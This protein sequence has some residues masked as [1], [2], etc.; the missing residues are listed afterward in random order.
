MA[1]NKRNGEMYDWVTH[2]WNPLA[3]ACSH[4]CVYCYVKSMLGKPVLKAKYSGPPR[5]RASELTTRL[6]EGNFIFICNMTDLFAHDVPDTCIRIILEYCARFPNRYLIQTKNPGR[7]IPFLTSFH[8]G[9]FEFVLATTIETDDYPVEGI[10]TAPPIYERL[11]A[12]LRYAGRKT[13]TIEPILKFNHEPLVNVLQHIRPEWVSIGADSTRNNLP[14]PTKEEVER[15]IKDLEP[16]TKVI[17][18]SN[19]R[20]ITDPS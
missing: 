14:E 16:F 5:L 2:T 8:P 10:S 4:D 9:D 6:G 18:K 15:L 12:L 20:R 7:A 11:D 19:L 13:I 17:R 3:G 1:L